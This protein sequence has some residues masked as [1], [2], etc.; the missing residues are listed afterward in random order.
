MTFQ[1]SSDRPA[2]RLARPDALILLGLAVVLFALWLGQRNAPAASSM[3]EGFML[4]LPLRVWHGAIQARDF[5]YFYGPL[6]LWSDAVLYQVLGASLAVERL[7]GAG[8]AY[9]VAVGLFL[10]GRIHSRATGV[11]MAATAV[12]M[13]AGTY[14]ALPLTGGLGFLLL[15][16]GLSALGRRAWWAVGLAVGLSAG[17]RPDFAVWASIVLLA[18][19]VLRLTRPLAA[20]VYLATVAVPYAILWAQ[21]GPRPVFDDLVR[22]AI[23]LGPERRLGFPPLSS[24][25]GV[26]ELVVIGATVVAVVSL[27]GSLRTRRSPAARLSAV[28]L[29]AGLCLVPEYLERADYSHLLP[30]ALVITSAA[31][32]ATADL[33][34]TFLAGGLSR[35]PVV[36]PVAFVALLGWLASAAGVPSGA[37]RDV[38]HISD[39][40]RGWRVANM[41]RS[42]VYATPGQ[43]SEVKQVLEVV[44]RRVG[45]GAALFVGTADLS[46][47]PYT[48]NSFYFLLP[49]LPEPG[50]F[51]DF[52]PGIALHQSAQLA[53][54][55]AGADVLILWKVAYHEPNLSDRH[56]PQT[57]N[58]VVRSEFE[59]VLHAGAYTVYLRRSG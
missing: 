32:L 11:V 44:D 50:H 49:Q 9:L 30:A 41:G 5:H 58:L 36:L 48:D 1:W 25:L 6:S 59:P 14:N 39:G 4:V 29:V 26:F 56:G 3:E 28:L 16:V 37:A 27:A 46:Q 34:T 13:L 15:G 21:A 18:L 33:A 51:Y 31:T 38:S 23:R 45:S 40:G 19:I 53:A 10:A 47:T 7:I 55:V 54:D 57:A 35:V 52:H 2:P 22:D 42:W 8:Y 12:V 20:A 24:G 17:L 43:A